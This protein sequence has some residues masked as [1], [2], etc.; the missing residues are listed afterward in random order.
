MIRHLRHGNNNYKNLG[1]WESIINLFD[2]FRDKQSA[3]RL[4]RLIEE[5][6]LL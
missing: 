3:L 5:K 6:I 2:P 1:D 4:R